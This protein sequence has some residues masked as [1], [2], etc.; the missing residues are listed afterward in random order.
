[1]RTHWWILIL[2]YLAVT[3]GCLHE[4][5]YMNNPASILINECDVSLITKIFKNAFT[6]V[7]RKNVPFYCNVRNVLYIAL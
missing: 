5:H 7:L 4:H 2:N 1:M 6:N 3:S